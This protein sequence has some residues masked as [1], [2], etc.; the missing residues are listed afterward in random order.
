MNIS[1]DAQ[2][3]IVTFSLKKKEGNFIFNVFL[4]STLFFYFEFLF[5]HRCICR[6]GGFSIIQPKKPENV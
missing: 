2:L 1:P 5:F 6:L 4:F 3:Y